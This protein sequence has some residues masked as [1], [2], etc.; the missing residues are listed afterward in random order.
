[1]ADGWGRGGW[2][3]GEWG[4]GATAGVLISEV[5]ATGEVGSFTVAFDTSILPTTVSA[6]GTL[7]T[8]TTAQSIALSGVATQ[9]RVGS[10][11]L[12][13]IVPPAPSGNWV[14]V[15]T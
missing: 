6:T 14:P 12:W 15:V 2:G 7:G 4:T 1:M 5:S 9:C 8:L 11:F 3:S 13:G 10:V